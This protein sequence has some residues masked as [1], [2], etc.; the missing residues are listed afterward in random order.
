M[1]NIMA[2][3][4]ITLTVFLFFNTA[5]ADMGPKDEL[6]VY[7]ENS[8]DE[9]YYLDLLT[10]DT[11][12]YDNFIR[13][14]K[15]ESFNQ[16]ML[17][18]LYSH[19]D[20]GWKPAFV[21]GTGVPMWGNLIGEQKGDKMLHTFGYVGVPDTYRI[22]IVTES[23]EVSVSDVYTRKAMQ[24]SITYDYT[25]GDV[26]EPIVWISYIIQFLTTCIPTLII[27]GFILILFG[28]KLKENWKVFLTVNLI[29]QV[30][31]TAILGTTLIKSGPITAYIIQFPV[32]L[33]IILFE[34]ILFARFLKGKSKSRR[35]VY[36]L[37]ANLASWGVGFFLIS[38]QYQ[39][40]LMLLQ[41]NQ[42]Y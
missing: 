37:V 18:L 3:I 38:Y 24:S 40:L 11:R 41:A 13:D 10:Q 6:K 1:K 36:G 4:M 32:E 42:N 31:L 25:T 14:E 33:G 34:S 26:T 16:E 2:V 23:G 15:R 28:F 9:L 35:Y 30:A 27:E 8:P 19:E 5:Y 21:E 12:E 22:I 29:T 39:L 20:E 7:V 17:D